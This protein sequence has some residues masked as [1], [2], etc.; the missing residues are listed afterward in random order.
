MCSTTSSENLSTDLVTETGRRLTGS[1]VAVPK[2]LLKGVLS[3]L[4]QTICTII[5]GDECFVDVPRRRV[6][7]VADIV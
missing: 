6:T 2:E 4:A 3:G 7:T 1:T 5:A